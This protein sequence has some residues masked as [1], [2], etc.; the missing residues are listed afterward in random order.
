MRA[1]IECVYSNRPNQPRAT[2][3]ACKY[4]DVIPTS[5]DRPVSTTSL[6]GTFTELWLSYQQRTKTYR[7]T[8][9]AL[10]KVS[11]K[12]AFATA[13]GLVNANNSSLC[14]L[15]PRGQHAAATRSLVSARV[16][17]RGS[18]TNDLTPLWSPLP[19]PPPPSSGGRSSPP[20][21]WGAGPGAAAT[22][23]AAQE[24]SEGTAVHQPAWY[25]ACTPLESGLLQDFEVSIVRSIHTQY[26][27]G[28]RPLFVHLSQPRTM[29]LS[30]RKDAL[31]MGG[32][33]STR[34]SFALHVT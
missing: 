31:E 20:I 18:P 22:L 14:P 25:V 6:G 9:S 17:G 13:G 5:F 1:C 29:Q 34:Y 4:A 32:M 16:S 27:E 19:P 15:S 7:D 12:P 8:L 26:M 21:A 23:A 24:A 33:L 3:N 28:Q 10:R 2:S 11:G 30:I